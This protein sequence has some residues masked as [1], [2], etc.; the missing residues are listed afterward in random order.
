MNAHIYCKQSSFISSKFVVQLEEMWRIKAEVN[1]TGDKKKKAVGGVQE[2]TD[3]ENEELKEKKMWDFFSISSYK[4][5]LFLST[6]EACIEVPSGTVT[7]FSET[8][9]IIEP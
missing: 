9:L 7:C 2:N 6:R 5:I 8:G 3:K 1:D 4:W